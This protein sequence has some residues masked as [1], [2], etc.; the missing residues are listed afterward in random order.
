MMKKFLDRAQT[1]LLYKI[2]SLHDYIFKTLKSVEWNG[3][4]LE[5]RF[6]YIFAKDNSDLSDHQIDLIDLIVL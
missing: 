4:I 6:M 2:V 1:Y 5:R 3:L